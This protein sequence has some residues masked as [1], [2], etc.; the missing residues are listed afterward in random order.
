MVE[1]P[2][3]WN[4]TDWKGAFKALKFLVFI[5][6]ILGLFFQIQIT[7]SEGEFKIYGN[8]T[9][10]FGENKNIGGQTVYAYTIKVEQLSQSCLNNVSIY[11]SKAGVGQIENGKYCE[12]DV[13]IFEDWKIFIK[14]VH[15]EINEATVDKIK[16]KN[17]SALYLWGLFALLWVPDKIR[18]FLKKLKKPKSKKTGK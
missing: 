9:F 16:I 3:D 7:F 5:L 17:V 2:F 1:T 6:A 14:N 13:I 12:D 18:Y 11:S 15:Q 8:D 4:A 10:D